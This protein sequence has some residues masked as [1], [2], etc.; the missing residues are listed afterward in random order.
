[1]S[2][3]TLVTVVLTGG[4][5]FGIGVPAYAA[6]DGVPTCTTQRVLVSPAVEGTPAVYGEAPLITPAQAA[7][8]ERVLVSPAVEEVSHVVH[9]DAQY[10]ERTV[11]DQPYVPAVPAVDEV[12]HLVHHEAVT[13]TVHHEAVTKVVPHEAVTKT[14]R[15][16]A[17]TKT[18]HHEA[19]TNVVHHDAVTKTVHH[20]AVTKTV[21]HEAVTHT[22]Y[23]R[24]SWV[25]GGRGPQ[26]GDTPATQPSHWN[27][28]NKKYDGSATG[29]VLHQGQGN[30]SYFYWTAVVV[31]DKAAWDETVTVKPAWDETVTVSEAWDEKV[32]TPAW[33]ET[34]VVTPA[35]DET[36][37]VTPAWEETVVVTPAWDETVVVTPAWDEKVID[38]PAQ[39]GTPEQPEISHVERVLVAEAWDEKVVD[40][41]A[42][43]AVYADVEHPAEPAV[44]GEAELISPAIPAR[45]AVYDDEKICTIV[46]AEGPTSAGTGAQPTAVLSEGPESTGEASLAQTGGSISPAVPLGAGA[47]IAGGIAALLLR[48]RTRRSA[49]G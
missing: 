15:H 46:S 34:V 41:A 47:L 10:A 43:D 38:V 17:V 7:W 12:S 28:D 40:V 39:P 27:A 32:V 8:I 4:L 3:K 37:V 16:D 31:T 6:Q 36:I 29:V 48:R 44:Y 42:Q 2:A 25:G 33:D 19:V 11:I 1:M 45:D 26:A 20:D 24:Y 13:G 35:W 30:G 5:A 49:E 18:V 23:T 22:E 21:H 9:H 14:V